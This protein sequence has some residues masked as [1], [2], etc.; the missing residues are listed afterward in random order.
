[1]QNGGLTGRFRSISSARDMLE[2]IEF[3][4]DQRAV[5]FSHT[6]RVSEKIGPSVS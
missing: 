4:I 6:V 1:L 2:Q 5:E 3:V